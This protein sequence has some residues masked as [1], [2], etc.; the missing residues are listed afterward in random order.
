MR[1]N[2]L[3]G[4]LSVVSGKILTL[5]VSL[6]T[7]P[8]LY[9]FLG[10]ARFGEYTTVMSIH[11]LFM[12]FVSSGITNGVR[13]FVAED[14]AR[15]DWEDGVVGFYFRMATLLAIL[16]ALG[17]LGAVRTGLVAQYLGPSFEPYFTAMIAMVVAAQFWAYARRTLMGFGLERYSEPLKVLYHVTFAAV[18]LGLVYSGFGVIGAVA[19]QILGTAVVGLIGVGLVV[20]R[21]S[22]RSLV[23]STSADLPRRRMLTYNTMA[24]ALAVFQMSLYHVDIIMLQS[25]IGSSQVG[26]YKAALTLAEFLWFVPMTLQT[27]YVHSTSELW[28]QGRTDRIASL[29]SRT[30]RYTLLLTT[31][32]ALGLAALA[33][34]VVPLYW[35]ANAG[36]AVTPLLI[37]LPGGLAFAAVR[38]TIAIEEGHGTLRYS[39][40]A[41]GAAAVVNLAL[42]LTLIPRYGMTGAAIATS[43]GYTSM[44]VFHIWSARRLNFDP[45]GDARLTRIALTVILAAGPILLLPR[46]LQTSA[47]LSD[48]G[49][50][51]LVTLAVVPPVGLAVFL[52]F[53]FLTGALGVRE[54]VDLLSEFPDPIGS[55]VARV[56]GRLG[57][58]STSSLI[59]SGGQFWLLIIGL[60]LFAS[61]TGIAVMDAVSDGGGG[62]SDGGN[63]T[64][65]TPEAETL[66]TESGST[67]TS[68]TQTTPRKSQS[69]PE[70][71]P[72]ET[73]TDAT[74]TD[75]GGGFFDD[76]DN[77]T[78]TTTETAT[79]DGG[80]FDDGDS[81]TTTATETTTD[82]D[83]GFFDDGDSE[84]ATETTD[85]GDN[86]T[87]TTTETTDDSGNETATATETATNDGGFF[88]DGDNETAT[89]TETTDDGGFFDGGDNET[90]T[91]TETTTTETN[92]TET[93]TTETNTTETTTTE[94]NTTETT[95]TESNTTETTTTET[96]TTTTETNTTTTNTTETTTDGG[97]LNEITVGLLTGSAGLL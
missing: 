91:T 13:K 54:C 19:G 14:R 23:L 64:E 24:I 79:E 90:A 93:T 3:S 27:V 39:V 86:E 61:G 35:G 16:G 38:P 42:N 11:A 36:P 55:T 45:L 71:T 74:T 28:S 18:A 84:T 48:V 37:L 43:I 5:L 66:Q 85:D 57:G 76:G 59:P 6:V 10:P 20:Q 81:E 63:A 40:V 33:E 82:D 89:T 44:F 73:R 68:E 92:T 78:A 62:L 72:T 21:V 26:N 95:T 4:V 88:D 32:M 50:S 15:S 58:V 2:I 51:N 52:A 70:E 7:M 9:R 31:V 65:T 60:V 94:T 22:L 17:Y 30:T 8:L 34:I 46:Y 67:T 83:G 69:T 75:D 49:P 80:F 29:A 96:N 25:L 87:V 56:D 12:I 47:A 77:E 97:L 41:T 1:R 53:A